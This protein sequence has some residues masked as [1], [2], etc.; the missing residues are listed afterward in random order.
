MAES[1][2]KVI[3]KMFKFTNMLPQ[4]IKYRKLPNDVYDNTKLL[5]T[6]FRFFFQYFMIENY[7]QLFKFA[8]EIYSS[9]IKSY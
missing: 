6:H 4:T 8:M 3:L 5:D 7:G 2:K 1:Y 9:N